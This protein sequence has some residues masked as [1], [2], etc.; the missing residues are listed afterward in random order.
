MKRYTYKQDGSS[1]TNGNPMLPN[2]RVELGKDAN[3]KE[4]LCHISP[5][6]QLKHL[7]WN[8][9]F[10]TTDEYWVKKQ[11]EWEGCEDAEEYSSPFLRPEAVYCEYPRWAEMHKK[12]YH[13][14]TV[15]YKDI[16]KMIT[17][18]VEE[19]GIN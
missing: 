5:T 3:G 4:W 2:Y 9:D 13:R 16:H 11:P 10:D 15:E 17:E 14:K 7:V 1:S 8:V 12:V 19:N 6:G 18:F